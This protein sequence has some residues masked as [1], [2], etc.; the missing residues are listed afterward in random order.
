M[1]RL[2]AFYQRFLIHIRQILNF[3]RTSYP[4][5]SG[6]AFRSLANFSISTRQDFNTNSDAKVV[7][8]NS[9]LAKELT[10]ASNNL[11]SARV[12][13]V[14]NGDSNFPNPVNLLQGF[15]LILCQN[16]IGP[17]D[18]RLQHLPIGL[19]NRRLGK[20]GMPSYFKHLSHENRG[21]RISKVL[22][23]PMSPTNPQRSKFQEQMNGLPS[24]CI[25]V[26]KEYLSAPRYFKLV[27]N[28]RFVLCL[29]GNGYDTHRIWES[30]YLETF[31]VVLD[32]PWS[33]ELR[34][35]G[36]PVL[37][38]EELAQLTPDILKQFL[39]NHQD[40]CSLST[41]QLWMPY[42]ESKINKYL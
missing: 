17:S 27:R 21:A 15:K 4:F 26:Y 10:K 33:T 23:P 12:L 24:E 37:V 1:E 40:F 22:V 6:D 13:I 2:L 20:S 14:G 42:W 31:P 11:S 9:D 39:L 7:F 41:P 8:I 36:I 16:L 34:R 25:E 35:M 28:Y 3:G 30:L 18:S 5:L 29:E 38:V 32:S 19:E